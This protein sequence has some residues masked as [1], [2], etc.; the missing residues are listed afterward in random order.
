MECVKSVQA[1]D[2]CSETCDGCEHSSKACDGTPCPK[3]GEVT[4]LTAEGVRCVEGC[5]PQRFNVRL[6]YSGYITEEA[7]AISEDEAIMQVR[8]QYESKDTIPLA[9]LER[10]PDA[11]QAEEIEAE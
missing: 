9:D 7:D 3:C 11:D 6:Y 10:W 8:R 1:G 4:F 2:Q 5:A